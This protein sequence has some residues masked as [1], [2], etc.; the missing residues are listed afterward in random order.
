M[1]KTINI[2]YG[3]S[4]AMKG[5]TIESIKKKYKNVKVMESAIKPW[6]YY[7]N[8]IFEGLTEYNDLT[9]GILH[10][11]RLREFMESIKDQT[12]EVDRAIVERGITDPLFYY[13]YN[14]ERGKGEDGSLIERAVEAEKTL[15]MPDF[16][17][18]KK[19][20]LI[21]GDKEFV[22]DCVLKDEY[23]KQT[24]KGDPELYFKMQ[25]KYVEFTSTY[26][27]PDE[28]IRIDDAKEYITGTLGEMWNNIKLNQ[29]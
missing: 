29:K 22:K 12:T 15:L 24:F 17:E 8:G 16:F 9:Y 10:L 7:Q 27:A 20:L 14:G 4:G 6:K 21:Q 5:S 2:Y 13:Y 23:R 3:L 11:V 1:M 19:I 28:V 18:V 25:E 26:N